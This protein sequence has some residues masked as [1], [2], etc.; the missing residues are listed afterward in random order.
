MNVTRGQ[1]VARGVTSR[2]PNCGGGHLFKTGRLFELNHACP[3]CGLKFEKDEG[4]YLGALSLNYGITLVA[5][6]VPVALLWYNK[7][8]SGSWAS[9]LALGGAVAIPILLY[10]PS[11]SWQLMLYYFFFPH[12]LP[13]NRRALDGTEDENV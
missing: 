6:L 8:I 12:H 11:R 4:F 13:A 1:I 3:D 9:G 5:G 10:R 2:C 7:V